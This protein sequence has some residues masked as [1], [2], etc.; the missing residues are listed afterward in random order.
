MINFYF[1]FLLTFF[2]IILLF[3]FK[4]YSKFFKIEDKPDNIR[5]IHKKNIKVL[6]GTLI[7]ANLFLLCDFY[8]IFDRT[9]LEKFYG[10]Q[11][12][13]LVFLIS[14]IAM[15]TIGLIDDKK[16]FLLLIN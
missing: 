9:Y 4:S 8:L 3:N 16:I 15:Y 7:I 2:N 11:K 6:G 14:A 13:F 10:D 12:N 5:K 1:L